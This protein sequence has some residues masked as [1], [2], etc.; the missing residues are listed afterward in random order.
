MRLRVRSSA[1]PVAVLGLTLFLDGCASSG[2]PA[3]AAPSGLPPAVSQALRDK[4]PVD[5]SL[6]AADN[7]L[8]FAP[9]ARPR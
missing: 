4:T 3:A 9:A 5:P 7:G 2:P 6:V 8:G 1:L